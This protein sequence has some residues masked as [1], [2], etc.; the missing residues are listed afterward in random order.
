M[1]K[2]Q[3]GNI[4]SIKGMTSLAFCLYNVASCAAKPFRRG[5]D[6]GDAQVLFRELS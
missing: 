1:Q 4:V 6:S 3:H 2:A 5:T